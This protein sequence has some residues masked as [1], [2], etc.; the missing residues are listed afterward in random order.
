MT[1]WQLA[2]GGL[3]SALLIAEVEMTSERV[4]EFVQLHPAIRDKGS[5]T[6][7][8]KV[9]KEKAWLRVCQGIFESWDIIP[10]SEPLL[11]GKYT[12]VYISFNTFFNIY[13]GSKNAQNIFFS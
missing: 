5:E 13:S 7:K 2:V 1:Y 12:H 3:V 11:H 8:D 10:S 9:E 6:Y 4:I